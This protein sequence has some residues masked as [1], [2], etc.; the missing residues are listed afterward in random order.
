[1]KKHR[2]EV[3]CTESRFAV[4]K[5]NFSMRGGL[6]YFISFYFMGLD[7]TGLD[8]NWIGLGLIELDWV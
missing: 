6:F 4:V 7:W 8:L 3:C 1:M 5:L 2:I